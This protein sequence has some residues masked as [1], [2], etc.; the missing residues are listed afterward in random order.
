MKLTADQIE[1]KL[2]MGG[3]KCSN[4]GDWVRIFEC[5]FCGS[6][7]RWPL[8]V[9]PETGGFVCHRCDATGNFN[10]LLEKLNIATDESEIVPKAAPQ[11]KKRSA[12]SKVP[13]EDDVRQAHEVLMSN[14]DFVS[15]F[16]SSRGISPETLSTFQVGV[17]ERRGKPFQ[18]IPYFRKG[19]VQY[20]KL[21][22]SWVEASGKKKKMIVREPK[23]SSTQLFNI[24]A[25]IGNKKVLVVEGEEDCMVLSQNGI[26][27]VVSL[28][29]GAQPRFDST[30][31]W[32]DD[33]ERF[34]EI[35]ICLDCDE[36][37]EAGSV[38]LAEALGKE[39]CRIVEY[40]RMN[41]SVTGKQMTDACDFARDGKLNEL[42]R[43]IQGA[44][45]EEHPLVDHVASDRA[46]QELRQDHEGGAPH[47]YPSGWR[48]FD[49]LLGG[50][51]TGELTVLTG[52]TGSG[53]SAFGTSLMVQMAAL[54]VPVVGA[55]F[56]NS[57]LD[58][59]WRI[60][61]RIVGKYPHVRPDG[62]GVAMSRV[63]RENGLAVL[64]ELPLYVV[65]KFGSME[66]KEFVEI[67]EYAKR[68]LG[69]RFV[70]LDH[71]HFMTQGALD[72]ERFVLSESIHKLKETAI[73]L[74]LAV[75]V[76][77]HPSRNAR[78]KK[79]PD[80]TDLHGSAAL[81]QVADNVVAVQR[82]PEEEAEG[83]LAAR[84]HLLKLRRGRSGR[85][86]ACDMEFNPSSESLVDPSA[87]I[88]KINGITSEEKADA[89]MG[90]F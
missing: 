25:C 6:T 15:H 61:Q 35:V 16:Q 9:N 71:L 33:L 58:F 32:L 28:P 52:H 39:R 38:A 74:D 80:A 44:A 72:R 48:C 68:R 86:G 84:V 76:V 36:A 65:D 64:A 82:V 77:C 67:C 41:S 57:P 34:K 62:S 27:N 88:M 18:Q 87:G 69:A 22:R 17:V 83:K 75:W 46:M 78:D 20:V 59:R 14:N 90:D 19:K 37:G 30:R 1:W 54:G 66:T 79:S 43:A 31:K 89:E 55:S 29:D 24:D 26:R 7:S 2:S 23:G 45:P 13:T 50:I 49:S 3:V 63:E 70:L 56:E 10:A 40:P 42:L 73:K 8:G 12:A 51:R 47:G 81:E 5:P 4:S 11:K 21:K 53:K 85:L 60:M